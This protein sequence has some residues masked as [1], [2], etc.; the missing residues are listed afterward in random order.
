MTAGNTLLSYEMAIEMKT[1]E[2]ALEMFNVG[3][4]IQAIEFIKSL[5]IFKGIDSNEWPNKRA[6]L[7]NSRE[8]IYESEHN[9]FFDLFKFYCSKARDRI[10]EIRASLQNADDIPEV[11][12]TVMVH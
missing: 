12:K 10:D 2:K 7:R 3:Q 4:A 1:L 8:E 6:P 5:L 11:L 9:Y